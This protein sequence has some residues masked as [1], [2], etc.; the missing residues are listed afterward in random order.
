M[1]GLRTLLPLPFQV[2]ADAAFYCRCGTL[3]AAM[4]PMSLDRSFNASLRRE[5]QT[6]L[7]LQSK[8]AMEK[9]NKA[10]FCVASVRGYFLKKIGLRNLYKIQLCRLELAL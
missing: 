4:Q 9:R 8:P 5:F 2:I 1:T 10:A 3:I 6:V 7:S